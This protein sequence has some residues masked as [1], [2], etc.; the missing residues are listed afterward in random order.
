MTSSCDAGAASVSGR[1]TI[2]V[3]AKAGCDAQAR[4]LAARLGLSDSTVRTHL[5]RIYEKT[6]TARKA[7]LIGL[8]FR[9]GIR[10]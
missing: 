7:E 9:N 2:A 3:S 6:R 1:R 5:T 8:L 10:G 4:A